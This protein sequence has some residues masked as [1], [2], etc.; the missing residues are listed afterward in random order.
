MVNSEGEKVLLNINT[1]VSKYGGNTMIKESV[2]ILLD[3]DIHRTLKKIAIDQSTTLRK[4]VNDIL[5]DHVDR[6]YINNKN[7]LVKKKY[8]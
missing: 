7:N 1:Q 8:I 6:L 4:L 3:R 5:K 2:S